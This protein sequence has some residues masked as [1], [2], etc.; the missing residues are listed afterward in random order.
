[1]FA[2]ECFKGLPIEHEFF[3]IEKYN[4]FITTCRYIETYHSSF[5]IYYMLIK[6]D[7]KLAEVL[8][9]GNKG[10]ISRCFNSLVD[11]DQLIIDEF[12]K[13]LFEIHPSIQ[14]VKIVSSYKKYTLPKTILYFKSDDHILNL[15]SAMED[16]YMKLGSS[17][18]QRIKNRK[19][20]LLRHYEN[21]NFV[22]KFGSEIEERTVDNIIE[23]NI[24]RMRHKGKIPVLDQ[25]HKN[26]IYKYSQHYG[27]VSYIEVDG[28]IVAGNINTVL[29]KK[30][31]GH[32]T[33]HD[34]N[35]SKYNVGELCAFYLIQTSIENRWATIHF[36]WGESD[37]KRRLQAK[38]KLLFSCFIYRSYSLDY[39]FFKVNE[40]FLDVFIAFKKSR[41]SNPI[42]KLIVFYRKKKWKVFRALSQNIN[43]LKI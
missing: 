4:S 10:I 19:V 40:L 31:F 6:E 16:Y 34:N 28:M 20:K 18:R 42:R 2:I 25:T 43:S 22:V 13:K 33:A 32:I 27:C 5:D 36:L 39:L 41:F 24:E 21:V 8:V 14:K 38:P 26:G 29:N 30:V 37:L 12:T 11:I 9:Y 3:L 7:N 15:P 1:M 23:M 35:F 17:T